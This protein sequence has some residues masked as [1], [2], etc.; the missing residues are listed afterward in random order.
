MN[1]EPSVSTELMDVFLNTGNN[2]FSEIDPF[3]TIKQK[4][5]LIYQERL[6]IT[7]RGAVEDKSKFTKD[8]I[9]SL[10]C[11]DCVN[12]TEKMCSNMSTSKKRYCGLL[13]METLLE[14]I[15][16]VYSQAVKPEEIQEIAIAKLSQEKPQD[17]KECISIYVDSVGNDAVRKVTDRVN[18][19]GYWDEMM[20]EI[21]ILQRYK[22]RQYTAQANQSIK[23]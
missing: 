21:Q 14:T 22:L 4:A 20:D 1:G 5:S 8:K 7:A 3:S 12:R 11:L 15:N 16:S 6:Y 9:N 18:S 2:C 13:L 19:R 17:V 23:Q 10:F